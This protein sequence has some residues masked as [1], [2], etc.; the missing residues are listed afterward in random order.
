MLL[1][2]VL[3]YH[4]FLVCVSRAIQIIIIIII[5][6]ITRHCSSILV[7]VVMLLYTAVMCMLSCLCNLDMRHMIKPENYEKYILVFAGVYKKP[8]SVPDRVR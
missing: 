6:I 8:S 2:T 3:M 7:A 5:V 4:C 1:L